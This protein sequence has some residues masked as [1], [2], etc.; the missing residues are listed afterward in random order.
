M[1]TQRQFGESDDEVRFRWKKKHGKDLFRSAAS[2]TSLGVAASLTGVGV[3]A[4]STSGFGL[5]SSSTGFGLDV[6]S[7]GFGS[8]PVEGVSVDAV[9]EVAALEKLAN[10]EKTLSSSA[11]AQLDKLPIEQAALLLQKV[12]DKGAK[13]KNTSR[14]VEKA[15]GK[16]DTARDCQGDDDAAQHAWQAGDEAAQGDWQVGDEAAQ[17]DWQIGNEAA[18]GGWQAYDEGAQENWPG[19][20]EDTA[21]LD[22]ASDQGDIGQLGG[23]SIEVWLDDCALW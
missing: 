3:A 9:V 7:T 8:A 13:I 19:D 17:G 6:S 16:F 18:Q 4:S 21:H 12:S 5:D 1:N 14:Y 23:G 15:A 22:Q 2:S 20:D 10:L 11:Q